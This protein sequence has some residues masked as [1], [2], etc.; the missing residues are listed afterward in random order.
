MAVAFRRHALLLLDDCHYALQASI[1][2]TRSA[3]HV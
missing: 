3:P 2:L 1:P